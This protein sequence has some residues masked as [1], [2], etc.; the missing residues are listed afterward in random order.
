MARYTVLNPETG[1]R[2]LKT[3]ALGQKIVK[4]AKKKNKNK[5]KKK[6][7]ATTHI[8]DATTIITFMCRSAKLTAQEMVDRGFEFGVVAICAYA[9]PKTQIKLTN[10]KDGNPYWRTVDW[11]RETEN[12][13]P[14]SV[15]FW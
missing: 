10:S 2:V 3:G 4:A 13:K 15:L 9:N 7:K 1:R 12:V 8:N 14:V 5:N 6:A 11:K